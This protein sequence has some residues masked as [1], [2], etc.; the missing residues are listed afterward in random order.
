MFGIGKKDQEEP[1]EAIQT[2]KTTIK[3]ASGATY[4]GS[5]NTIETPIT[6][7]TTEDNSSN[8][9][10]D[11]KEELIIDE[12][13]AAP[14]PLTHREVKALKR[15]RYEQE[16]ANNSKFKNSYVIQNK[17]TKQ[18]VEL[19]AA[20]PVHACNI[21]GWKTRKVKVLS[22]TCLEQSKDKEP[23]TVSS[24]SSPKLEQSIVK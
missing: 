14:P 4:D 5:E 3:E 1:I 9:T 17:R 23:E 11:S 13:D 6:S 18:V 16:I 20:S 2:T 19:R 8:Q 7:V 24:S 10:A 12:E 22:V 21:I 15:S